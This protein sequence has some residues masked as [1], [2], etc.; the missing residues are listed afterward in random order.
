MSGIG[1]IKRKWIRF[2]IAV[3]MG[4]MLFV[5]LYV[6]YCPRHVF[7]EMTAIS[8]YGETIDIVLNLTVR[9]SLSLEQRVYGYIIIGDVKHI[10]SWN[11][12]EY[13]SGFG[14]DSA[15]R[16]FYIFVPYYVD[17][18]GEFPY[19]WQGNLTW[20]YADNLQFNAIH[21]VV[22]SKAY[23]RFCLLSGEYVR[24]AAKDFFAPAETIYD[25][26]GIQVQIFN[27]QR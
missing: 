14:S 25:I 16:S 6:L 19:G 21:L 20:I 18:Y 4:S 8:F 17:R 2:I 3:L 11:Y 12:F 26:P 27:G 23:K 10:S 1:N 24:Q 9:R 5:A 7:K 15:T 13:S 22:F